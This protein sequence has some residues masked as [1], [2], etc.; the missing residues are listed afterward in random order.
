VDNMYI[1]GLYNQAW[2]EFG[3]EEAGYSLYTS[4]KRQIAHFVVMC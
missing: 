3:V 2:I 4:L 1:S